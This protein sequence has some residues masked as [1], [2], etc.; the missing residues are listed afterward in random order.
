[1]VTHK[2]CKYFNKILYYIIFL[3][4]NV[5]FLLFT[6]CTKKLRFKENG[7]SRKIKE[8]FKIMEAS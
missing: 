7:K 3:Q 8:Y 1:M 6:L 4:K 5:V 2:N